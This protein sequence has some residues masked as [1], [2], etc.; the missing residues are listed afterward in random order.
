M[1]SSPRD[2]VLLL[3]FQD[4]E[5]CDAAFREAQHL[6]GYRQEAS[7][8]RRAD[9]QL[10]VL[11][12]HVRGT[13]TATVGG[14][15][16]GLAIGLLGGPVGALLGFTAGALLGNAAEQHNLEAGGE[17]L[18][19]LSTR[20]P[21]D[22]AVLILYLHERHPDPADELAARHGASVERLSAEELAAEIEDLKRR[23]DT[24]GPEGPGGDGG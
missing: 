20:V 23:T 7:V 22:G 19:T 13:G 21:D 11:D 6:P 12:T 9:G 15:A 14:G 2:T 24:D 16:A 17:A 8:A 10:E 3:T 18:I 4:P 5:R 1:E